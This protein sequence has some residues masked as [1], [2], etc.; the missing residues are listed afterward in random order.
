MKKISLIL[1]NEFISVVTRPSFLI[2]LFLLPILGSIGMVMVSVFSLNQPSNLSAGI[3]VEREKIKVQGFLDSG[4]LIKEIPA[5]LSSS[6]I[7]LEN[8]SIANEELATGNISSYFIIPKDYIDRGEIIQVQK[9]FNVFNSGDSTD[10]LQDLLISNLIADDTLANR[11]TSPLNFRTEYLSPLTERD[12]AD[13]NQFVVPYAIMMLLYIL[14][15]T[16]A[17]LLLTSIVAE[18]QNRVME[19]LLT[20]ATPLEMLTGKIIALGMAGLLQMVAW[21]GSGF[22]LFRLAGRQ[23]SLGASFNLPPSIL[24]W[25]VI[26][27]ILGYALYASLMA[28]LGAL[29]PNLREGNQATILVIFPLIIPILFSSSMSAAPNNPLFFA[30]SLIPFTSPVTMISRMAATDV[31]LWQL[32]LSVILLAGTVV[33]VLQSVA[34]LFRAQN[35]LSG[36]SI[37]AMNLLRALVKGK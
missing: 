23:F 9:D 15:I 6:F 16:S 4:I 24:F 3:N 19:I 12:Q 25:G 33:L 18:K 22:L 20:S 1:K 35:L 32:L 28:G 7:R 36:N 26:F 27:F 30:L 29:V 2:T 8:E 10:Q 37:K 21:F 14:I 11:L 5:N 17:S 13:S 34:R 31:P